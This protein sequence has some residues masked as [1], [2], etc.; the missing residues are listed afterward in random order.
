MIFRNMEI[1]KLSDG[2]ISENI[3]SQV[4][5]EKGFTGDLAERR[6]KHMHIMLMKEQNKMKK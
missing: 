3:K 4:A 1:T 6:R 5:R 2:Q